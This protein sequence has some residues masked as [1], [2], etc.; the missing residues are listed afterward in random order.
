VQLLFFG[1]SLVTQKIFDFM[2][3]FLAKT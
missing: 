1:V 2:T 3:H